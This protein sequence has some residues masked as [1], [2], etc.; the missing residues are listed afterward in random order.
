[1]VVGTKSK[2]P[3]GL[4]ACVAVLV[5]A[6]PVSAQ[7]ADFPSRPITLLVPFVAGGSSDVVMRLVSKRVS[8]R[9]K[10]PS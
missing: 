9:L 2:N 7:V 1:M 5:A 10:Q 8:E 3:I 4:W 6:A